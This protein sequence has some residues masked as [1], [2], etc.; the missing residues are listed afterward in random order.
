MGYPFGEFV[1]CPGSVP[2][3]LL[4]TGGAVY[5]KLKNL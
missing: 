4:L 2:C 1:S 3:Q 5:K